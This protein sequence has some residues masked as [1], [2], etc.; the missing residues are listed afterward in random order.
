MGVSSG[1]DELSWMPQIRCDSQGEPSSLAGAAPLTVCCGLLDDPAAQKQ[2]RMTLNLE[3]CGHILVTGEP[4]TGKTTFLQTLLYSLASNYSPQRVNFYILDY[5]SRLLRLFEK[6]PHCG[7]VLAEE[8]E[9]ALNLFFQLIMQIVQERKA[10]FSELEVDSYEAA[11]RLRPL[12]LILVVIDNFAGLKASRIGQAH[13]ERLPEYMKNCGNYGIRFVMTLS[14]LNEATTRVK[15]ELTE[16]IVLHM[17]DK[18]DFAD[19]LGVRVSYLPPDYGGRG[20]YLYQGQPLEMQLAMFEPEKKDQQRTEELKLRIEEI[21][22]RYGDAHAARRLP[23][24]SGE[25]TYESFVRQFHS[26]R[27]PLGYSLKDH[28]PVALP[29]KQFSMLSVYFGNPES[30]TP[31]LDNLLYAA[32]WG[33]M[34]VFFL[35]NR[36]DSVLDQLNHIGAAQIFEADAAGIENLYNSVMGKLRERYGVFQ[37][38]CDE[39][40]LDAEKEDIYLDAY[41]YM[42]EKVPPLLVVMERYAD[43]CAATEEMDGLLRVFSVIYLLARRC[44]IYIVGCFYPDE[45]AIL[46]GNKL[47]DCFNKEKLCMLFGGSLNRQSLVRVPHNMGSAEKPSEYNRCLMNYRGELYPLLMPCGPKPEEVLLEDDRPIFS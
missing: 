13:A 30:G 33:K 26:G 8:Q 10:L 14:Y 47:Y 7:A 22:R 35:K 43:L 5:S 6:L 34:E 19:A 44:Q 45:N 2:H 20:L 11:S 25:E 38:Y 27:I 31:V 42:R 15:Q 16:R 3:T 40:H 28:K 12:P 17:K 23:L 32:E 24:I 4:G 1:P 21:S 46:M 39:K 37:A 9:E 36:R 29:L 41:S 18:Y